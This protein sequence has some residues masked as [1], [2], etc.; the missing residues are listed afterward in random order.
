VVHASTLTGLTYPIDSTLDE[1]EQSLGPHQFFRANRQFLVNKKAIK[2][3][4]FYFNGRLSVVTQPPAKEQILISK[5]R[6]PVLKAWMR[7]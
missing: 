1:L 4:E 2:E 6:V 5:A 3:L 7:S